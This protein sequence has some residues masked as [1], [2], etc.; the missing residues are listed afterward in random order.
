MAKFHRELGLK[1]NSPSQAE[2]VYRETVSGLHP[3]KL[4]ASGASE[5]V[6]TAA[7]TRLK[8]LN[9]AKDEYRK[10]GEY[11]RFT[12]SRAM[13]ADRMAEVKAA[14]LAARTAK[15]AKASQPQSGATA[16]PHAPRAES[17]ASSSGSRSSSHH[18]FGFGGAAERINVR[19]HVRTARGGNGFNSNAIHDLLALHALLDNKAFSN[20]GTCETKVSERAELAGKI[21][22]ILD[23]RQGF[24]ADPSVA[25]K[26]L[27]IGL[28]HEGETAMDKLTSRLLQANQEARSAWFETRLAGI[29]IQVVIMQ[30]GVTSVTMAYSPVARPDAMYSGSSARPAYAYN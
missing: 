5:N 28:T 20:V 4:R 9:A 27:M 3:D 17:T 22:A 11:T 2:A 14:T 7:E 30:L 26:L 12:K 1:N 8:T 18:D 24:L 21:S 25:Q 19:P 6:I 23:R 13:N 10:S 16:R 15:A 29:G